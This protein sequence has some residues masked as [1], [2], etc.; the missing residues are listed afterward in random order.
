N[1]E[2]DLR[3]TFIETYN[4]GRYCPNLSNAERRTLVPERDFD[5]RARA[6]GCFAFEN[7]DGW[8]YASARTPVM[9]WALLET[10]R[11]ED[12]KK[13]LLDIEQPELCEEAE[14]SPM[15]YVGVAHTGKVWAVVVAPG[16][17]DDMQKP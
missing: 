6:I 1:D 4:S 17:P 3:E 5:L 13:A 12:A 8:F 9:A 2:Q 16:P 15:R 10:P 7:S 11:L 14:R